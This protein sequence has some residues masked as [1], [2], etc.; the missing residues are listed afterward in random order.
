MGF[1]ACAQLVPNRAKLA[2][3]CLGLAG[4]ET[5][6]PR[7]RLPRRRDRKILAPPQLFPGYCFV[8]IQLQ[9]HEARWSPGVVRLVLDGLAPARVPDAVISEL[10]ARERNGLIELP[11]PPT[12]QSGDRVR[13][14]RGLFSGQLA[15]FI[16]MRPRQRVEILLSLLGGQQRVELGKEDVE[17]IR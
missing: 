11:R 15:L 7:L 6:D 4:F 2:L 5:Y 10:R 17:A 14:R 16:G 1:W 12:V 9:W 13:V 8:L 3:H